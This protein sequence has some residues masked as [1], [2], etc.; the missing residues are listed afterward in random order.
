MLVWPGKGSM[1]FVLA[2]VTD[3]VLAYERGRNFVLK[4]ARDKVMKT[5]K[6]VYPAPL[7][8]LDVR[9]GCQALTMTD[10]QC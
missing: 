7:K 9:Q 6:G 5:T 1:I 8:I 2:E 3:M 10:R 4:Q